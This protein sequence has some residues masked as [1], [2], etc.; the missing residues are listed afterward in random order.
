[1][2]QKAFLQ[3]FTSYESLSVIKLL[4]FCYFFVEGDFL[5]VKLDGSAL[6]SLIIDL[7]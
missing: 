2:I 3:R 5:T 4:G 6:Q 7:T 1:M